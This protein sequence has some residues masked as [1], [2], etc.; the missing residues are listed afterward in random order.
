MIGVFDS[1]VG[2]LCSF[3]RLCRLVKNEKLIYLADEENAPYGTKTEKEITALARSNIASLRRLGARKILIACCTAS[4]IYK[5]LSEEEKAVAVPIIAP[6][7]E[8]ALKLAGHGGRIAVISTDFTAKNHTFKNEILSIDSSATV[9][10]Y[11]EQSLV[12]LVERGASDSA[13]LPREAEYL[14][15]LCDKRTTAG[16]SALILG[17]THFSHL[18]EELKRRLEGI[19]VIDT[20]AL[21]ADALYKSLSSQ[22]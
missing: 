12:E 3:E 15:K 13:I 22:K 19:S 10:E 21:G 2:G 9:I 11:G 16:A 20:A 8:Q 1:G 5:N 14:D 7:A 6:A 17:C 18:A 4:G